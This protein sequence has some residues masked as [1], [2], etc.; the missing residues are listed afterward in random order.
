VATQALNETANATG[1]PRRIPR[2]S[3]E[4]SLHVGGKGPIDAN[5]VVPPI[6][7][8]IVDGMFRFP[9]STASLTIFVSDNPIN[10]TI[11]STFMK[12]KKIKY[13]VAKN[14]EEAVQKW[15][16]GGFHLIL[17]GFYF[18]YITFN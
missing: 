14:G 15:R 12:K 7:V 3:P 9:S 18:C 4:Q 2:R 8:L 5:I 13:D 16:T 10:Q 17:V 6:S 1:P 11:L